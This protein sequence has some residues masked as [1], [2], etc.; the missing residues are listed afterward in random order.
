MT[1]ARAGRRA[2]AASAVAPDR[3]VVAAV[4]AAAAVLFAAHAV[5]LAR[6]QGSFCI[7][8]AYISFRYAKN[9]A[10]GEGLV[11]NPGERVEGYTNFGWVLLMAPLEWVGARPDVAA[12]W[13]NGALGLSLI[14]VALGFLARSSRAPAAALPLAAAL[15]AADGSLARWSQDGLETPLFSLLVFI[16]AIRSLSPGA[17]F[18]VALAAATWVRPEGALCFA[19]LLAVRALRDPERRPRALLEPAAVYAAIVVPWLAWKLYYYGS[20]V[21]NTFHAK[22]GYTGAQLERGLRYLGVLLLQRWHLLVASLAAAVLA[23]RRRAAAT[24]PPWVAPLACLVAAYLGYVALVGGDWMGPARFA[25]PVLVPAYLLAAE[26]I[27]AAIRRWPLPATALASVVLGA[28]LY[29]DTS[30]TAEQGNLRGERRILESRARLADW[31]ARHAAPGDTL[32]TNE[33]GQLAYG[34]GLYTDDVHGLTDRHVAQLESRSLGKGKAGHEKMDLA[35]SFARKPTWFVMPDV[36]ESYARLRDRMPFFADYVPVSVDV[37][38]P[39]DAYRVVL[40]R[41]GSPMR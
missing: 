8:D 18:A 27:G 3:R 10:A 12:R 17:G 13:L 32:L 5:Q 33:I 31:V 9:L 20:L 2:K 30:L 19:V 35:Y 7:D 1:R 36:G 11:F 38:L 24:R 28:A 4:I 23:G 37:A 14:C 21:P 22:V 16:G 34:S 25:L 29:V 15:L 39:L 6:L 41:R 26:Q 40:H